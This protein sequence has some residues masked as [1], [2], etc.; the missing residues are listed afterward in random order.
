MIL[1]L[2]SQNKSQSKATELS[3]M[4]TTKIAHQKLHSEKSLSR[5][6]GCVLRFSFQTYGSYEIHQSLIFDFVNIKGTS[7]LNGLIKKDESNNLEYWVASR[8]V[9]I[10]TGGVYIGIRNISDSNLAASFFVAN[11]G[12]DGSYSYRSTPNSYSPN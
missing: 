11:S 7:W 9:N 6:S 10:Y 8:V 2:C 12:G 5:N 1:S 4:S 3:E